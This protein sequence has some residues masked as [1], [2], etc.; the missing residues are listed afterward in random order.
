MEYDYL[1]YLW[2]VSWFLKMFA[3]ILIPFIIAAIVLIIVSKW[4]IYQKAGKKGWESLI[5]LYSKWVL[6]DIT[7]LRWWFFFVASAST[8]IYSLGFDRVGMLINL[9]T[10][11]GVYTCNYNLAIKFKKEPIRFAIGLTILPVVFLP[12]IAF[13]GDEYHSKEK[14]SQYGLFAEA[15]VNEFVKTKIH[16][17][18]TNKTK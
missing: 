17:K 6:V 7:G 2:E 4:K 8:L 12:M 5:P 18:S 1:D 14:V 16:N 11:F 3:I 10:I 15:K 13:S 9:I